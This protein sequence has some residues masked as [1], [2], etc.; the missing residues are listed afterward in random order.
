M[1]GRVIKGYK[2]RE[3]IGKGGMAVIYLAE[4][5]DEFYALKVLHDHIME[6]EQYIK[7]F[8]HEVEANT[9]LDHKNI[10][11]IY[12]GGYFE[13]TYFMA[14]EYIEG[15][16]LR[17]LLQKARDIPLNIA[18]YILD[19][20]LKA[21]DYSH[22]LGII[23]RDIKPANI[24]ITSKGR[25]KL[26][27]FGISKVLDFTKLTQS[28]QL[29]GTPSYM[30]P[31]QVRGSKDIDY[32]SDIFS[33][34]IVFYEMIAGWN[35]FE[36]ETV[37]GAIMK[38]A[39]QHPKP[40]FEIDPTIPVEIE[41][42]CERMLAKEIIYRY[43]NI[44]E[45]RED[46][47]RF[48][49]ESQVTIGSKDLF[50]FLQDPLRYSES[51]HDKE[52]EKFFE[53]G[54]SLYYEDESNRNAALLEFYRA[55]YLK[56][57]HKDAKS[58]ITRIGS[59]ETINID[60]VSS[61]QIE[62][63][64]RKVASDPTNY[65]A[66]MQLAKQ[67]QKSGNIIEA[68][69]Y[70]RRARRVKPGD[71]YVK[72]QLRALL[73]SIDMLDSGIYSPIKLQTGEQKKINEAAAPTLIYA[74][75]PSFWDEVKE[76]FSVNKTAFFILLLIILVAFCGYK[77][78]LWLREESLDSDKSAQRVIAEAD[79]II[80][81]RTEKKKEPD[82]E[83]ALI[84]RSLYLFNGG[85]EA[86]RNENLDKAYKMFS[87]FVNEFP[88][89]KLIPKAHY[90]KGLVLEK[91]GKLNQAITELEKALDS[92]QDHQFVANARITKISI[93]KKLDD[94]NR[95]ELEYQM[96]FDNIDSIANKEMQAQVIFDYARFLEDID[97]PLAALDKY[98]YIID[99]FTS[100][101]I[102]NKARLERAKI[103]MNN[104][105]SN[106]ARIDLQAIIDESPPT[107]PFA[108]KA[109]DLLASLNQ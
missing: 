43:Q 60:P 102:R 28:G 72:N 9:R 11:R 106:Y 68:I 97:L 37:A 1:I 36:D 30:S 56:P 53:R 93:Y 3:I 6:D 101:E 75:L 79:K 32:R 89:H 57:D 25:V 91:Q 99:N 45:I 80:K 87:D 26:T 29:V 12:D 39:R 84:G 64:Q 35:P 65:Q 54:K 48:I 98:S 17:D 95:M 44:R 34:G 27:D 31:E 62:E 61:P 59:K 47:K 10:V 86:L 41:D 46:I 100:L 18:L 4:K 96:L 16:T 92:L 74:P 58:Y 71:P 67:H 14:M 63:L 76:F 49:K 8:I 5:D 69:K 66:L 104:Q 38:I 109:K 94:K 50:D 81:K 7:R 20:V 73:G 90:Y 107:D 108:M 42:L 33:A 40:L 19:E 51:M 13:G 82:D 83:N 103:Y 105:S 85:E 22:Q 77:G 24:L 70:Y 88:N 55:L 2:I 15:T 23:H 52:A 78:Y 21:L